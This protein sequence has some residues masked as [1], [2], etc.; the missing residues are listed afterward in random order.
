MLVY[1]IQ[2]NSLKTFVKGN[3]EIYSYAKKRKINFNKCGKLIVANNSSEEK[4]LSKK[5]NAIENG[6]SLKYKDIKALKKI[7]P[8]LS[9]YS[10]LYSKSSGI[11]D[12][13]I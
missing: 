8:N 2:K 10:A 3:S 7:E 5:K 4:I 1:I 13:V 11:I 6:I 9:C 12:S